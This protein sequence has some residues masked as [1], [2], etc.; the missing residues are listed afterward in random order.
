MLKDKNLELML[1]D[2]LLKPAMFNNIPY[3]DLPNTIREVIE[4]KPNL[5]IKD[6]M[7]LFD[8][9]NNYYRKNKEIE[10]NY[11]DKIIELYDKDLGNDDKFNVLFKINIRESFIKYAKKHYTYF[12][13]RLEKTIFIEDFFPEDA[14]IIEDVLDKIDPYFRKNNYKIEIG[15]FNEIIT[16]PMYQL[17]FNE[18]RSTSMYSNEVIKYDTV[19]LNYMSF[20]ELTTVFN[21]ALSQEISQEEILRFLIVF[22]EKKNNEEYNMQSLYKIINTKEKLEKIMETL[23]NKS[24]YL[25]NRSVLSYLYNMVYMVFRANSEDYDINNDIPEDLF[26]LS[27]IKA[28][29]EIEKLSSI[30]RKQSSLYLKCFQIFFKTFISNYKDK[31]SK[32]DINILEALFQRIINCRNS[33]NILAID[34]KKSLYHYYKTNKLNL[35][36]NLPFELIR[37]YNAKHYLELLSLYHKTSEINNYNEE[38]FIITALNILGYDL[39]KKI[40]NKDFAKLVDITKKLDEKPTDYVEKIKPLLLDIIDIASTKEEYTINAFFACFNLLYEQRNIKITLTRVK[41]MV[42]SISYALLPNNYNIADNLEKLNFVHKGEPLTEKVEGIKLY[43]SYRFRLYSSIPNIKGKVNNC[44]YQTV[45]MHSKEIISNGIEKYIVKDKL[46]SSCLTP[47]GKASSCLRHGAINPHGRFFKVTYKDKIV[48][49]SWVWRSGEVLCFDN[50]EVTENSYKLE[51]PEYIIYTAY[52]SAAEAIRKVTNEKENSGIKLVIIGRND[53]DVFNPFIDKLESVNDYTENLFKPNSKD[54]LYLEDSSKKQLILSGKYK[55]DL[56]TYDIKPIYK[57]RRKGIK[58]FRDYD[59]DYIRKEINSIYFDYCLEN[60]NKYKNITTNYMDGYINEDWFVGYK[61][62]NTYDFYYR[63]NDDRLFEEAKS[64]IK[65]ENLRKISAANIIKTSKEHIDILLDIKNFQINAKKIT[66]YLQSIKRKKFAL[67]EKY[68]THSP[69][70]L[71]IFSKIL[72]DNA[73]TSAEY[74]NHAGGTGCNGKNFISVA[75]VNSGVYNFYTGSKTFI[76]TDNI[77]VFGKPEFEQEMIVNKFSDSKYPFRN[78]SLDGELHVLDKINL[79]KS[80]GIFV[81]QNRIDELVQIVYLQELFQNEIP[82]IQFEDNTYIDKDVI[83]K[84]S[85]VLK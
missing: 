79:D 55:N 54:S 81:S 4:T 50:I 31:I 77:C 39:T 1:F 61:E 70:S 49:Y 42:D 48:A 6:I 62:N 20:D 18:I 44:E 84:Y 71:E 23:K 12:K 36:I 27:Y 75:R 64:Y 33:S 3:E 47:A 52:K 57:Y 56:K 35:D 43:D 26:S 25:K 24:H 11:F 78:P 22:Y 69:K 40:I 34:N 10:Y 82:L 46:I 68:Y 16:F 8:S 5:S 9:I 45:D 80:I 38:L 32:E 63:G 58:R 21:M 83:K 7:S 15:N 73:I 66:T 28:L 30:E 59:K 14:E 76:L 85:K 51:N 53:I 2:D 65:T 19:Y 37:N 72:K 41:N 74:G 17:F 60:N 29:N 67:E 13:E